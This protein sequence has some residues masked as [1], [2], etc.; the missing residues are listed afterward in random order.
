MHI[1]KPTL[2]YTVILTGN[3]GLI[4]GLTA[5]KYFSLAESIIPLL[6][7]LFWKKNGSKWEEITTLNDNIGSF[8]GN[9]RE[10]THFSFQ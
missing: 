10:I 3:L 1:D 6:G 4:S 8:V 9:L 2:T 5:M 7:S